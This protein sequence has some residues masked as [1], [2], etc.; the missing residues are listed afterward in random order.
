MPGANFTKA[1]AIYLAGLLQNQMIGG[2]VRAFQSSFT[3]TPASV[4]ADFVA[5]ECD[6]TGY[7]SG[8]IDVA[9]W[10]TPILAPAGGSVITSDLSQFLWSGSLPGVANFVGGFWWENADGGVVC[11][12]LLDTPISLSGPGQGIPVTASV[13]VGKN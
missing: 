13:T 6:Y 9:A 2:K 8:G 7:V 4:K 12:G 10:S 5:A 3:P 11:Y 1:G